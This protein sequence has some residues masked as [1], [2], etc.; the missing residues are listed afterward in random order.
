MATW[1]TVASTE[2]DA[3]SPVT[4]TLMSALANN[5]TALAEQATGAPKIAIETD[6][7]GGNAG[8][9]ANTT[10]WGDHLGLLIDY[11]GDNNGGN[12]RTV[13]IRASTDNG[14]TWTASVNLFAIPAN[15]AAFAR[16]SI[17]FT[18]GDVKGTFM[19]G[20]TAG[21]ID[22]SLAGDAD[23]NTVQFMTLTDVT[24]HIHVVGTGGEAGASGG[25][26]GGGGGSIT[27]DGD[28]YVWSGEEW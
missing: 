10:G 19:A 22:A 12:S 2:V 7:Q 27:P 6:V 3:D 4:A 16:L 21:K 14:S 25:G 8:A 23:F 26:G 24:H 17:D 11:S 20:N 1:R 18:S 5:P 15:S 28:E 9:L 13:A